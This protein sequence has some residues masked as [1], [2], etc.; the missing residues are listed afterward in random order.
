MSKPEKTQSPQRSLFTRRGLLLAGGAAAAAA[1]IGALGVHVRNAREKKADVLVIGA[2]NAGLAAAVSA[3]EQGRTVIV[4]EKNESLGLNMHS[5]RGLF[6]SAYSPE[7]KP[8]PGDSLELHFEDTMRGGGQASDP[9]LVRAFVAE[10]AKT[11]PWLKSLG[12]EF[13]PVPINSASVR[14]RC[15]QPAWVGYTEI[16]YRKAKALGVRIAYGETLAALAT[17]DGRVIGAV[18][19]AKDGSVRRWR[20]ANGVIIASGGFAANSKL[21]EQYA[22]QLKGL[23]SDNQPGATGEALEIA[24]SIGA[25]LTGMDAIQCVARPPGK[26]ANQGYLHLDA[27]RFIYIDSRGQ[28]FIRETAPRD[29]VTREFLARGDAPVYELADNE[30]VLSYQIDIQKDLWKEVQT[31]VAVKAN[32]AEDLARKLGIDPASIQKTLS[33]YNRGAD[34]KKDA[35]GKPASALGHR[36]ETPPFWAVRVVMMVHETQGGLRISPKAEVLTDLGA[37]IPGL[38]AAGSVTG[39]LHGKNRLGGNGIASAIS[40]GRIAGRS[41]AGAKEASP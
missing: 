31:G 30:A 8:I 20:A 26:L 36:I 16:L 19:R 7:G 13:Q 37:V 2:G 29:A 34:T 28:R 5:D 18:T 27:S 33:A 23:P 1:G 40:F 21:V 15:W 22:P 25:G 38:W 41:A 39:G 14:A 10:A 4:L 35:F 24:R 17:E 3:A 6:G 9:A 12:M 11:L 32:T